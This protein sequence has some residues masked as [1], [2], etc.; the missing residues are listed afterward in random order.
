M[1]FE[2]LNCNIFWSTFGLNIIWNAG[3]EKKTKELYY[4][5]GGARHFGS[6]TKF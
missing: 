3:R 6:I 4:Q 2:I 1:K 5:N